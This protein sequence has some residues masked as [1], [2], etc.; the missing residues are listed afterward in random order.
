MKKYFLYALTLLTA[1]TYTSCKDDE[2]LSDDVNREFMTMFRTD[3]NTGKGT[4]D[5][6]RCQIINMNDA[7]LYWY[8]VDGCA[9][10]EI[11][12]AT[13][14]TVSSGLATDW[15]NPANILV[16]TIMGPEQLD[17]V[18][19]DLDYSTDYRFAI[20]TLSTKGEAYNSKWYGYGSGRQWAEYC[21]LT[22]E[23]RYPVPL[24]IE[25]SEVT[26]TSF[27]VNINRSYA[28]SGDNADNNFKENFEVDA[29]GNYVMQLLTVA[30][31]ATNP[32]AKVPDQ[33]KKYKL[34][35]D[36]FTRGYVDITGLDENSVY[37]VNVQ[38]TNIPVYVDAI[39]NSLAPRTDGEVGDPI[40][41]EHKALANDTLSD[42]T[43]L[44]DISSY[45]ACPLDQV[46]VNYTKDNTLAEGTI[47]ELEGG[48]TYYFKNNPSLCKGMTIRTRAADAAKG[49]RAKVCLGG[50]WTEGSTVK[51][52]NFMFGRQPVS[53]ENS[54]V[55]IYIKSLVFENIDF[56]CPKAQC[57]NGAA[58]GTGNYFINMYS[59]GMPVTLQAFEVHNCTFQNMV[60]GF[61][62]VQGSKRKLFEKVLVEG[63]DFYNNGYYDNNG[64]GYAWVA[65]DGAQPKSNIFNNMIFRDNT[66]YDSP[67]TCLFTDNA[68]NL[69]WP[70][71]VK[72]NITLENNTFVNF[73]TRS[74][75]RNIFDLKYIPAGSTITCRKNLFI[76][77]KQDNDTRNLYMQGMYISQINGDP[78]VMTFNIEDNWST[79]TNLTAGQIFSAAAFNATSNSAGKFKDMWTYGKD[80]LEVHVCDISPLE[81]MVSPNPPHTE[82]GDASLRH[83]VDNLDGIYFRNTDK[84]KNSEIY[85]KGIGASK[86]RETLK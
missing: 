27:R 65:G 14:P 13:Q 66:F 76:L 12:M 84:V 26:K 16:D 17:M 71:S 61:I 77:T 38:N 40:L 70:A 63:C 64:R 42:G 37:I 43:T 25:Q 51:S 21:G 72:Y 78:A 10:Y 44:V 46:L 81:L 5:P 2:N 33:F 39:Y 4:D 1:F 86:W 50:L 80:E 74:S 53:G 83:H 6:Y 20:R 35:D 45:N 52:C 24:V 58:N 75:G 59:N 28:E 68:K 57:F 82:A 34:T 11:K 23:N 3:D 7:H 29:N 36:D 22:T 19:K 15:E 62:R 41:I 73:S 32:D 31:S 30:A 47:F 18:I 56:D 69:G 49:L 55:P 54:D 9:G 48:K 85:T 60:R 67:R 79:N 8:G